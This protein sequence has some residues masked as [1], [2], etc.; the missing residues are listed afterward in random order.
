[1]KENH[2]IAVKLSCFIFIFLLIFIS[3][4]FLFMPRGNNGGFGVDKYTGHGI[5]AEEEETLDVVFVGDSESYTNFSPLYIFE[6]YGYTSY[7]CGTSGQKLFTSLEF[8]KRVI[9]TQ[10]PEIIFLETNTIF[11]KLKPGEAEYAFLER[12]IPLLRYHNTWKDFNPLAIFQKPKLNRDF[13][14]G[15]KPR[16]GALKPDLDGYMAPS[17]ELEIIPKE[18]LVLLNKIVEL[19]KDN[20]TRLVLV[21][22]PSPLN[23]NMK[24]HNSIEAYASNNSLSY[25]DLNLTDININWDEDTYDRGD[26]LNYNGT[27]KVSSFIGDY[28]K[29]SELG[30]LD[31]RS[32]ELYKPWFND[33]I[34]YKEIINKRQSIYK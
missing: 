32:N 31:Q 8:V 13:L 23:W 11:R 7:V 22:T 24:R 19:A 10:T 18:N 27:V 2:K 9:D 29:K 1:M 6:N 34:R 21:S 4:S 12:Y 28:L 16:F 5:H 14:K 25:I 20:N 30:L 17:D 26:H 3:L 33:I 15:H